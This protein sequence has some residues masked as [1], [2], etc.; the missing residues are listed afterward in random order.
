[1]TRENTEGV[2]AVIA[3][4]RVDRTLGGPSA[5]GRALFDVLTQLGHTP[6][7][8]AFGTPSVVQDV[9]PG[10]DVAALRPTIKGHLKY[11]AIARR[12]G[13]RV[14][15]GVWHSAFAVVV[16]ATWFGR[17]RSYLCP[18]NSLSPWDHSKKRSIKLALRPT[19]RLA[20][21]AFDTVVFASTGERIEARPKLRASHATVIHHASVA[22]EKAQSAG[23]LIRQLGAIHERSVL[24]VGRL[25]P[26]KDLE[27]FL[28]ACAEAGQRYPIVCGTAEDDSYGASL[29]ELSE[30]LGLSPVWT[31][32]DPEA[33]VRRRMQDCAAV[34][35]TSR[36]ENFGHVAAEALCLGAPVIMVNRVASAADFAVC[37]TVT[38]C[39]AD[40]S[41]VAAAINECFANPPSDESV[42]RAQT[43]ALSEFSAAR[44]REQW[45]NLL[46][47]SA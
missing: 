1:M 3:L 21:S 42:S 20:L 47:R 36:S 12:A 11:F 35:I 16:V 19:L 38:I 46:G 40:V 37:E 10:C 4:G 30:R 13:L 31:G 26:Q 25:V 43:W 33:E 6:T 14:S 2:H 7:I 15:L 39:R 44:F 45:S 27:L 8:I 9:F 29:L 23:N 22:A 28:E 34:C 32:W 24:F 5:T 41:S 17:G 18:T